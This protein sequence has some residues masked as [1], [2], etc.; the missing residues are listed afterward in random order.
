MKRLNLLCLI[1]LLSALNPVV[2]SAQ[3]QTAAGL[4]K[5]I[6]DHTGKAKALIRIIEHEGMFEGKIETILPEEGK[7]PNPVCSKCEGALHDQP[8]LGMTIL[9][10]FKFD[11]A[12][13]NGGTIL[14]PDNGKVY[15]SRMTLIE[16]GAKLEVRG[17]I[18][19]PLF[20]RSQT[21]IREQ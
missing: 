2:A 20:G 9:K 6:D 19:I 18:G 12:E 7:D 11:G 10:G 14:D 3:G 5:S 1:I 13:Y 15:K 4:W 16:D 21:W 17:Y 8:V